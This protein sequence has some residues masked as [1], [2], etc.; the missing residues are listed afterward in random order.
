ML[1]RQ[2]AAR[3]P[4]TPRSPRTRPSCTSSTR[5]ASPARPRP[6]RASRCGAR[7]GR[8]RRRCSSP[9]APPT[10]TPAQFA[11]I[12]DRVTAFV[13]TAE[14]VAGRDGRRTRRVRRPRARRRSPASRPARRQ[15][16]RG[17]VK[18]QDG[19]DCHCA[20]CI[21]PTVRGSARSRP[22]SAVLDEARRRVEQGQPEMVMTGISV[23]DYRDPENGL[24]LGELMMRGRAG[25]RRRARAAVV[26]RGDPRQGLAARR[27]S[28]PSRK[29]C[30]HLHV[31]MQSGDDRVLRDMG[32]HYDVRR[33]PGA[34]RRHSAARVPHVNVTTDVIVGFPTEDEAAFERTLEAVDDAG[35][36]RVH[37]FRSRRGPGPRPTRCG[38]RV[39]PEEKKRRSARAAR[40]LRGPLAATTAPPS[41]AT[42]S[43]C[44]STRCADTQCSGYSRTTPAATCRPGAGGARADRRCARASSCTPTES[45]AEPTTS[46]GLS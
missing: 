44:W 38:D 39:A 3:K 7:S 17:F 16:T 27:R 37:T 35:I 18:V 8:H 1:A 28:P 21:I 15:R 40:S 34:D 20:Y 42:A 9:A 13:G 10:S 30:P 22:A 43:A 31:P 36:T 12:D 14:D 45:L 23:G 33:V 25:P 46:A 5:A 26:R 19:C 2:R 29:V 4:V 32:R 41:S 11:E 6:S 24:E